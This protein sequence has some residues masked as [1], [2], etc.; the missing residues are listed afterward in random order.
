VP[1]LAF[2]VEADDLPATIARQ[3]GA[4]VG[5]LTALCVLPERGREAWR[6]RFLMLEAPGVQPV[7]DAVMRRVIRFD[8]GRLLTAVTKPG[9]K[10]DEGFLGSFVAGLGR[11]EEEHRDVPRNWEKIA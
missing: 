7:E 4:P 9:F 10:S 11:T 2:R 6:A 8:V 5:P 1:A 3:A